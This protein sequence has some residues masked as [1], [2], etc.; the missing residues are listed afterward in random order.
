MSAAK[1]D[2]VDAL[3]LPTVIEKFCLSGDLGPSDFSIAEGMSWAS[4]RVTT[5]LEGQTYCHLGLFGVNMPL[6]HGEGPKAFWILKEEITKG[7]GRSK[8]LRLRYGGLGH[9]SSSVH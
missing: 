9:G 6:L 4:A 8:H 5:R 2:L 3:H 1:R 7:L